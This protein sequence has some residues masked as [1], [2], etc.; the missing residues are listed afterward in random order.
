[1]RKL[2]IL[3]IADNY[4]PLLKDKVMGGAERVLMEQVDVL[5]K[6]GHDIIVI[7]PKDSNLNSMWS[8]DE[9]SKNYYLKDGVKPPRNLNQLTIKAIDALTQMDTKPDL[10]I[11]H[12]KQASVIKH[13]AT[14]A[15]KF[16][17]VSHIHNAP[18]FGMLSVAT[19]NAY[20]EL[21][22][23]GGINL[24]VSGWCT[25]VNNQ[26]TPHCVTD[27]L[28]MQI[29]RER[30]QVKEPTIQSIAISRFVD[31][32]NLHW[33]ASLLKEEKVTGNLVGYV[34]DQNDKYWNSTLKDL[35]QNQ[36]FWKSDLN[37]QQTMDLLASSLVYVQTCHLE[38]SSCTQF[39]AAQ[40]GVPSIVCTK[41]NGHGSFEGSFLPELAYLEVDTY[42]LGWDR[43][44]SELNKVIEGVPFNL[45]A[46]QSLADYIYDNFNEEKWMENFEAVLVKWFGVI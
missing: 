32:K 13:L 4:V 42:R 28:I 9:F 3:V 17:I 43:I 40:R 10:I 5:E 8:I 37:Y 27:T 14:L 18:I 26:M 34:E 1:M 2:N 31:I 6:F 19:N 29:A 30:F 21:A 15:G 22:R 23:A 41:R 35:V 7:C 36:P 39:E 46:R 24:G 12:H 11:N 33:Y 38:T 44:S 20:L 45:E 16:K 25:R